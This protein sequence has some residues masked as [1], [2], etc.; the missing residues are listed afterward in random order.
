MLYSRQEPSNPSWLSK[1][2]QD[3][4][5]GLFLTFA[6][7]SAE[8]GS[9]LLAFGQTPFWGCKNSCMTSGLGDTLALV[10]VIPV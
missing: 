4:D 9:S 2:L 10:S 1:S 6:S 3:G 7:E 5:E 8:G